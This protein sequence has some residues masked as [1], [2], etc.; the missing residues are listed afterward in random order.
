MMFVLQI[1]SQVCVKV[2]SL[3]AIPLYQLVNALFRKRRGTEIRL[4]H[5]IA[6]GLI[7]IILSMICG[8]F[9]DGELHCP[10]IQTILEF[11]QILC[12]NI[13]IPSLL[14]R[15]IPSFADRIYPQ[16]TRL[17]RL[18]SGNIRIRWRI[19]FRIDWLPDFLI[20][21]PKSLVWV[22]VECLSAN[23]YGKISLWYRQG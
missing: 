5:R 18:M 16:I 7:I 9:V 14:M 6:A 11:Q 21:S 4:C 1:I 12:E 15:W 20:N 23:F 13:L 19:I 10:L 2:A 22:F 3:L 8:I 17:R